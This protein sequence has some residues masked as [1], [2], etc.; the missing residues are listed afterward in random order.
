VDLPRNLLERG[1]INLSSPVLES[2]KIGLWKN[3]YAWY[4]TLTPYISSGTSQ[5]TSLSTAGAKKL[6]GLR[7]CCNQFRSQVTPNRRERGSGSA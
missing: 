3:I 1:R 4:C 2:V 5:H 7:V 6:K